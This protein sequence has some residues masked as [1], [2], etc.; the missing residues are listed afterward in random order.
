MRSVK[1]KSNLGLAGILLIAG[2]HEWL[3]PRY[4]IDTL[5]PS[6]GASAVLIFGV[7]DSKLAQPRNLIGRTLK[8]TLCLRYIPCGHW[9]LFDHISLPLFHH[10][11]RT[12]LNTSSQFQQTR[13][14]AVKGCLEIASEIQLPTNSSLQ[15]NLVFHV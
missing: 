3:K 7:P 1:T 10:L 5:V 14:P 12:E 13:K 9:Q 11:H 2:L 8:N 15:S 4:T 6:F